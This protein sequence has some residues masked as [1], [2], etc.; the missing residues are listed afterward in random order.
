MS[1]P[2]FQTLLNFFKALSNESRLKLVGILAQRE[3]SVEELAAL[4]QLK[5]P[6]VSHHLS[7]LKELNLVQMRPDRNT[8]FYRL[9]QEALQELSK[10][11]FSAQ[12]TTVSSEINP[13]AWEEKVLKSF[14]EGDRLREIPA[15]RKKR[16]VILKWLVNHFEMDQ[17][18]SE[19]ALNEIIKQIHPDTATLRRELIGYR[20]MQR[21]NSVYWREPESEW[22]EES[23]F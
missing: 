2:E 16:W 1:Q 6:T 11:I 19:K 18:Y 5:E 23:V 21:E 3:Y 9:N 7:K 4:V 13:D 15:S 8:H 17:Q 10:A 20:M 12:I 14:L 22:R